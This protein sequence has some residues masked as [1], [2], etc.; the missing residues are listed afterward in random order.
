[1]KKIKLLLV[2]DHAVMRK[3]LIS[4]LESFPDFAVVGDS[5]DG[6]TAIDLARKLKPDV[7]IADLI[8]PGLDGTE[9]TR[10]LIADNPNAKVLILTTFGT[11]D[12][13]GRALEAGALGAILKSATCDELV[14]AIRSVA[15]GRKSVAA[16]IEQMMEEEPPLPL[17]TKRQLEMLDAVARGLTNDDIAKVTGL[18]TSAVK[19]HLKLLFMKMNVASRA[20]ATALA[21]KKQL[22][23]P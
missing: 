19:K 9:T 1:M 5:S 7:V 21:L 3:G 4:L 18:S 2:D 10:R 16:E 23:Q 11:A 12:G 6:E 17:L 20:E 15:A 22:L 8:M 13:L 14:A